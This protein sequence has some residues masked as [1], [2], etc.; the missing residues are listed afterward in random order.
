MFS[1]NTS[2]IDRIQRELTEMAKFPEMN[3]GP[4]C[5]MNRE[6]KVLLANTA[7]KKLFGEEILIEKNW[8]DICIG[9]T[10]DVWKK[11]LQCKTVFAFETEIANT[12]MLFNHVCTESGDFIFSFGTD[13]TENKSIAKKLAEQSAALAEIARFPDMNPGPVLRM[14]SESCVL[15]CNAAA[16]SVFG[17]NLLN[18]Y[19]KNIC[20][21]MTDQ[22][23]KEIL[24]SKKV[25]P[26]EAKVG[27]KYFV[28]NHRKD[29]QSNLIFVFGT[30]VTLQKLAE[31]QLRQ[32][33]KMATLGTLAAGVAHELNNPAAATRRASQ[34]LRE[35]LTKLEKAR[36][37]LYKVDMSIVE[38][39]F[40]LNLAKHSGEISTKKNNYSSLE[41]SDKETTMEGWLEKIGIEN[42]W[43][44][45]PQ[46]VAM[47]LE[48]NF[49]E[50]KIYGMKNDSVK[51]IFEW[52]A[53]LFPIYSLL[54]EIYEG[55]SR[56][57]E[58][59][60]ALKNY[61]FLGQAPIQEINIHEGIDNTLVILRSKL[62][63][64][65]TVNR[66]YS[67]E[68]PAI[69]VYGSEL[70]Q[71]WTNILDN[72]I[73]A[74]KGKGNITIRTKKENNFALVEIEDNGPGIP[75]EIQGR[76]FDPFF[77][78][79]SPGKGTGLGL[80]TSYGII[81]EKHQGNITVESKPGLTKFIVKLPI[82]QNNNQ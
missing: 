14:N 67:A 1:E 52:I 5:R 47:Q 44:I 39:E 76:I 35:L 71:V 66:E 63:E 56:I 29:F 54:D 31:N 20:P 6:G 12:F 73:D 21:E 53:V 17:A 7:A 9:I 38:T 70:N 64:G 74:M 77:T 4:V 27:D 48:K 43:E 34:Q 61:S 55:S 36:E 22:K 15:L 19:W 2:N 82:N 60:G 80:S 72:A 13:I 75:E 18:Q 32:S 69:P 68:L 46:L 57:S 50:E 10:E 58:I 30:D 23:W 62:K 78:T 59:V 28:F 42:S 24:I 41:T 37:Q 33:E 3:P 25:Y 81:T 26:I 51:A 11:I 65:V 8:L 49:L 79:K 45:A 16:T 40:M